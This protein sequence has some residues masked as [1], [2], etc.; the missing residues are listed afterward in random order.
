MTYPG[1]NA[2]LRHTR[3]GTQFYDIPGLEHSFT[4]Y[5]GWNAALRHTK[6]GTQ[7]YDIPGLE[8]S[9]DI[10]GLE[11]SFTTYPTQ[12]GTQFYDIPGLECSF[13]TYPGCNTV[14][15]HIQVNTNRHITQL[16]NT[17]KQYAIVLL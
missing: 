8:Q 5:P 13:M 6:I 9:Y 16:I 10:P 3:V 2:V 15:R 12:I 11:R 17:I 7:F 1:W 14:L 4:T